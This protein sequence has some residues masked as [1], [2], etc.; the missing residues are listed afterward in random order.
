MASTSRAL[1]LLRLPRY[2]FS[3]GGLAGA[4]RPIPES[5]RG[6]CPPVAVGASTSG[7]GWRG[8]CSFPLW[9]APVL[10][11]GYL[12]VAGGGVQPH[13][14]RGDAGTATDEYDRVDEPG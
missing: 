7:S 10:E 14:D 8:K 4:V 1:E 12:P 3:E 5:L 6:S 9:G 13:R 2:L 11:L